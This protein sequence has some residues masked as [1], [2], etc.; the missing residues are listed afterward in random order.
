MT[1]GNKNQRR[2]PRIPAE[3]AV[4][5]KQLGPESDEAFAKTRVLGLGGC[6]FVDDEPLGEG[7]AIELLISIRG[8][9]IKTTARVVY[10][11]SHTGGGVEI[12]C[13][14][15]FISDKDRQILET[16]FQGRQPVL[17]S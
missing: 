4:L 1:A 7:T 16:I 11:A 8:Q 6:M 2:F 15:L 14:F 10:E 12:G 9:V 5:V 3:Y 13:E 17:E